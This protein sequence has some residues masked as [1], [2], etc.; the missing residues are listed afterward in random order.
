MLRF[1]GLQRIGHDWATE[2]ELELEKLSDFLIKHKSFCCYCYC[3]SSFLFQLFIFLHFF[4]FFSLTSSSSLFYIVFVFFSFFFSSVFASVLQGELLLYWFSF[5]SKRKLLWGFP[6][7][8][9]DEESSCNEGDTNLIPGL[10]RCPGGGKDHPL[11]YS[12]LGNSMNCIVWTGLYS[13]LTVYSPWGRKELDLTER[14]S[15]SLNSITAELCS[16]IY[17]WTKTTP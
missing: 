1:T 5:N 10:G 8:S 11:Y 16:C 2:L 17:E 14:L 13:P 9:T 15:L 12:G 4:S 3:H 7:S 6:G